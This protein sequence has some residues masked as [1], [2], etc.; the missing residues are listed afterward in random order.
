[1]NI[2]QITAGLAAAVLASTSVV[3]ST[4]AHAQDSGD[5]QEQIAALATEARAGHVQPDGVEYE[6]LVSRSSLTAAS[7]VTAS[8]VSCYSDPRGDVSPGAYS[9]A[10]ITGF[11]AVNSGTQ[12][13]LSVQVAAV[14]NPATDPN[15]SGLTGLLW[16]LYS[17]PTAADSTFQVY[18]TK[19]GVSVKRTSGADLCS[20]TLGVTSTGYDVKFP[21]SC[22]GNPSAFYLDTFMVYDSN[23]S[24]PSAPA[25]MDI[26]DIV[27]P[28]RATTTT[29]EPV[30][31]DPVVQP[32]PARRTGRLAG[33]DRYATA[34]AISKNVFPNGAPI[35]FLARADAFAD[36]L[37]GGTLSRGPILLVPQCGTVPSVV[38]SEIRRLGADEVVALGGGSA[39]CDSVLTQ[40]ANA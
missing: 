13:G 4:A 29:T 24:D 10:D 6:S 21:S 39:V 27:G 20:G 22:I 33:G 3:A 40:A 25:Y 16:D 14:T 15:W 1:M 26:T 18:L 11:C 23:P 19:Y 17:S 30:V 35:V 38:L 37:A 8:A 2:M 9:R 32:G 34:V 7:G 28:I 5:V 36:A 12:I 31:V